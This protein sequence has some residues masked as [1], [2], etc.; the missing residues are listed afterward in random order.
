MILFIYSLT[1]L[2]AF[3]WVF[4]KKNKLKIATI[5]LIAFI[6]RLIFV[7]LA[8]NISNYDL[9]SYHLVGEITLKHINIYPT[10]A[11]L[12]HPYFPV[13]LYIESFSMWINNFGISYILTLKLIY[14]LFDL[15]VVFM[16]Y[17]LSHRNENSALLYAL[18]PVS[19]LIVAFQGQFDSVAI[20]HLL[21]SLYL[22]EKSQYSKSMLV[23]S[24]A[25]AIK[26]WPV[27][28]IIPFIKRV[29]FKYVLILPILPIIS[30]ILYNVLFDSSI[31][32]IIST[33]YSYRG[34][35]GNYGLGLIAVNLPE[36]FY[37]PIKY[38]S[39]IFLLMGT[40]YLFY[41][42]DI[43]LIRE[44]TFMGLLFLTFT[45]G[46]GI[47]WLSWSVPF[48]ILIKIKFLNLF[49]VASTLY[50]YL[51]YYSWIIKKDLTISISVLSLVVWFIV[52]IIFYEFLKYVKEFRK[53][54]NGSTNI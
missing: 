14:I 23:A 29:P 12:H 24:L 3:L 28:F 1:L 45:L 38:F 40:V 11:L 21:F 18:N 7:Y 32:A 42:R 8:N 49:I 15:G 5:F 16:V 43:F 51:N 25:I 47:Q 46:F 13:M 52:I 4:K 9:E 20:F 41:K 39:Y 34:I 36:I 50:I 31:R 22:Y 27:I 2:F 10:I 26:T 30:I 37:I 44:I 53:N 35:V 17:L 6:V 54:E 19:S 48:F 33:L